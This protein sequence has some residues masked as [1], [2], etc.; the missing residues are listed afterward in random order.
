MANIKAA[1]VKELRDITGVGMMDAKKALV[2]SDGEIDGAINYLRQKGV[3]KASKK[4]DRIAS[5]GL[6]TIYVDGNTAIIVEVNAETDFVAKNEKFQSLVND[7]AKAI[8]EN[9]PA[10]VEEAQKVKINDVTI[11][12]TIIEATQTI[13]EKITL[14][15]F[16]LF[17]KSDSE[18]FGDYAHMGGSISALTVLEGSGVE[19][20]R[21]I[22][23]HIAAINPQYATRD[24]VPQDARD[25]EHNILVEQAK[26]EGKPENIV[27]KMVEG[28]MNKWLAEISLVDQP[29]VKDQ[30]QTVAQYLQSQNAQLKA[31][32]RFEVGEGIE[33][34]DE[35]FASEVQSQ[36]NK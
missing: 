5:E 22:S 27:E 4:A 1:Q 23:M 9:K 17:E 8:V 10:T 15:R 12:D 30:D 20:A 31:F 35:D 21:N 25:Q 13:G 26:S 28:R 36:I 32:A 16:Q 29:Y 11:E 6:S 14:R 2:E 34:R 33:K 19:V 18:V 7:I 3:S 24:D